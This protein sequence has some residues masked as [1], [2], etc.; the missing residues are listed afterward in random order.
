MANYANAIGMMPTG[1]DPRSS[2][3]GYQPTPQP[4]PDVTSVDGYRPPASFS[5]SNPLEPYT[6]RPAS[7]APTSAAAP[8]QSSA[9]TYSPTSGGMQYNQIPFQQTTTG[10]G[11]NPNTQNLANALTA[12]SNQNLAQNV[13]PQISQGAQLA[14]QYGGSRQG[15]AEG[16]AAGNAQTGLNSAIAGLYSNA[17]GQDQNFYTQ[18]RGQDQSGMQLGANLYG[19]GNTG[20]LGIGAGQYS[21]GQTYMNA[22]LTAAQNYAGIVNPYSGL[23]GSSTTEGGSSSTST[24]TNSGNPGTTSGGGL[25]GALG[26]AIG[27]WQMGSNFGLG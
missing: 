20:N 6:P 9:A 7:P 21:L 10:F 5:V 24:T 19:M 15:I 12:Q 11:Q 27:G 1:Q 2:V 13:M 22:P 25:Q 14:G 26:G 23:N 3:T 8:T 18:Q 17:Y 4:Y 16:V